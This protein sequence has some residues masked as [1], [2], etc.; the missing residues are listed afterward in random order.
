MSK[1]KENL[2]KEMEETAN[3]AKLIQIPDVID[4]C[5]TGIATLD[6]AIAN[7]LPGG[8]PVGRIIQ[9]FGGSSTAKSVLAA[10]ILGYALRSDKYAFLADTEGTFNP[11]FSS[12]FGLAPDHENFFYN[13]QWH[14]DLGVGDRPETIEEFF[15][16]YLGGILKLRFRKPMVVVVDSLTMLPAKIETE[17]GMDKQGFGAYRAKQ[18][19]LG[20]RKYEGSMI[21]KNLTLVVVD[22]TRDSLEA[23][24]PKEVVPGGRGLEFATSVRLYLQHGQDVLNSKDK[25]IG[26]W[27]NFKIAKNKVAPPFRKGS[28]KILFD[29]GLDEITSNLCWLVGDNKLTAS[30][31]IPICDKC[32]KISSLNKECCEG[33][34]I[35]ETS[36]RI[37]DWVPYIEKNALEISLRNYIAEQWEEVYKTEERKPRV[38]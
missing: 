7:K 25:N 35:T 37:M 30:V 24:G 16:D 3:S 26:V 5:S 19:G 6:L 10:T 12:I 31:V 2:A 8:I 18:I 38:W 9:L 17:K 22:Q 11:K 13:Y 34:K 36:K 4:W 15:D 29:Y 23:F 27:V 33:S 28:F 21:N 14:K 32:G 1:T 20:L